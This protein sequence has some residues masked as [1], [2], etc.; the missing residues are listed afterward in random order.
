MECVNIWVW[1]GGT[2]GCATCP[3]GHVGSPTSA[4]PIASLIFYPKIKSLRGLPPSL[5]NTIFLWRRLLSLQQK[6]NIR[7]NKNSAQDNPVPSTAFYF[8]GQHEG[9]A[10]V[11][12]SLSF[13]LGQG[14]VTSFSSIKDGFKNNWSITWKLEAAEKLVAKDRSHTTFS[15]EI[16]VPDRNNLREI[17]TDK[18]S[19]S[20]PTTTGMFMI[21]PFFFLKKGGLW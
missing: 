5:G 3:G 16:Y 18:S 7:G 6:S 21:F 12:F 10:H 9:G 1:A 19:A 13:Y 4:R 17:L 15:A 14:K 2:A 20:F 11:N 8:S